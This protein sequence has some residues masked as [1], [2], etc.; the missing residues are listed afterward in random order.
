ML[1]LPPTKFLEGNVFRHVCLSFPLFKGGSHIQDRLASVSSLGP[2]LATNLA[3]PH[4]CS[5]LFKLDCSVQGAPN[6][7]E[8]IKLVRYVV[9]T[10]GK[11]GG[12]LAFS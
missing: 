2:A 6:P 7:E 10:V 12:R 8:T 1:I 11:A 9:F 4:I 3:S 5:N